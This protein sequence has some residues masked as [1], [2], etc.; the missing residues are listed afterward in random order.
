MPTVL[1][2]DSLRNYYLDK[3]WYSLSAI[4]AFAGSIQSKNVHFVIEGT[5]T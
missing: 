2:W 4:Q 1:L 3:C 5:K